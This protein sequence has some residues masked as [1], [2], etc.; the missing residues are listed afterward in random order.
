V[1][2]ALGALALVAGTASEIWSITDQR[3]VLAIVMFTVAGL[4]IGHLLGGPNHDH[5][6]VLA[7]STACR[8]P[9]IALAIAAANFP[10]QRFV[11]ILLLCLIVNAIAGVPYLIWQRR[12]PARAVRTA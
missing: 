5:S 9:A 6:V 11:A 7:L 10:G 3:S 12:P 8:H 2:L 4:A 1:L